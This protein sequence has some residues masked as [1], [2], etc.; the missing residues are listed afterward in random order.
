MTMKKND[1]WPMDQ[2][3]ICGS[4]EQLRWDATQEQLKIVRSQLADSRIR[5][6]CHECLE[7]ALQAGMGK[8]HGT[9]N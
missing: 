6:V 1:E 4:N 9:M 8:P 7:D 5:L 3:H 2:C